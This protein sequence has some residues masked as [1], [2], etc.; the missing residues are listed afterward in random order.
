[1]FACYQSSI[2]SQFEFLQRTWSNTDDKPMS[3]G[4]TSSWARAT[5]LDAPGDHP[6]V[7]QRPH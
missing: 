2:D 5:V 3:E 7:R 4:R 1:M 6:A